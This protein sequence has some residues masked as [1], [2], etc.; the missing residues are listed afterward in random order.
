MKTLHNHPHTGRPLNPVGY[1]RNGAPIWPILGA[2]EDDPASG[3]SATP[4]DPAETKPETATVEDPEL[5]DKGK[6]AIDR[7]KAERD[8]A[9]R[10]AA[11]NA[12]KVKTFEDAQKTQVEKDAEVRAELEKT[13]TANA[14][15]ALRYEIAEK[16]GLPLSAAA[17]LQGATEAELLADAEALKTLLGTTTET[18]PVPKPDKTQAATGGAAAPKNLNEAISSHYAS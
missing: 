14:A 10:E 2:S 18:K 5:G 1:R 7:M 4:A 17:R 11:E 13:S 16:A 6:A 3:P 12:A 8:A 9:K 15:K